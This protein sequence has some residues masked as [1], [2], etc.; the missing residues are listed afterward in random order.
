MKRVKS[1]RV[2]RATVLLLLVMAT[3]T[4]WGQ[5]DSRMTAIKAGLQSLEVETPGLSQTTELSV[6][7]VPLDEFLRALAKSHKL[8]LSIDQELKEPVTNNFSNV[9]VS[10][11]LYFLAER[12]EL[13]Y[14]FSANIIHIS[15]YV[16][17]VN[18]SGYT[19]KV[20]SIEK[21]SVTGLLTVDF[22]KDSLHQVARQLVQ[23]TGENIVY[24]PSLQ[25]KRV[26]LYLEEAP[27]QKVLEQLCFANDI[28]VTQGQDSVFRLVPPNSTATTNSR[29]TS[30]RN[31]PRRTGPI[32]FTVEQDSSLTLEVESQPLSQIIKTIFGTLSVD[33]YYYSDL[34]G[35]ITMKAYNETLD[36]LLQKLL[37]GTEYTYR[38]VG[39]SYYLGERELEGLRAT[40]RIHLKYRSIDKIQDFIPAN[41]LKELEVVVI[42]ELNSLVVSGS[43]PQIQ[44]LTQYLKGIDVPVPVIQIEVMIID[45][46]R[47]HNIRTGFDMGIGQEP[48]TSGG[49]I[50]PSVEYT[51]NA[52]SIN[53]II[54]SLNGWGSVNLGPVTPN[55]YVSLKALETNGVIKTRSTPKLATLNGHEANIKIGKTEYYA[56]EQQSLQ[57]VQNPIPIV[58]RNYQSVTADFTL[59]IRPF[60][61]GEGEVTLEIEVE[62]SDFTTRIAPDAPPGQVKRTFTTII[63]VKD[64]EMILIGGL[65]E[66]TTDN[67]GEGLPWF[68]RVPV[69]KWFFSNRNKVKSDNRLNIFIKPTII[70]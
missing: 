53:Q 52:Q 10:D 49:S 4:A 35:A 38:N 36:G 43:Y 57:G 59:T 8:N 60:V 44:E 3:V 61:S 62:Q 69:L 1:K 6:S 15:R 32:A 33:Y 46:N 39:D 66:K 28:S 11:V 29:S 5:T 64:G 7:G 12:H 37:N 42:E 19:P 50:Y 26:T 34:Q 31:R 51:L 27:L 22:S 55:F 25:G 16:P 30:N 54:S 58:T 2:A 56:V 20:L 47:N 45:H 68:S 41:L 24:K 70:E 21:D 18:T 17:A 63:R 14:R 65:E 13:D 40:E 9:S 67:T 48:A 23:V